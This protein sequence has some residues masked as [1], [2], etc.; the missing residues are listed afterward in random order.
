VENEESQAL[1]ENQHPAANACGSLNAPPASEHPLPPLKMLPLL[2]QSCHE[3]ELRVEGL[4][5]NG[6]RPED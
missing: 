2:L 4:R 1:V 3:L 6:L 5:V